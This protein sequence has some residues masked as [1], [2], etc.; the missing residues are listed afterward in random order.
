MLDST[1]AQPTFEDLIGTMTNERRLLDKLLFRHAEIAML[2]AAG[3][4]RFVSAA[5]DEAIEVEE[6]VGAVDLA[7]AITAGALGVGETVAE[8]AV[9]APDHVAERLL[10]LSQQMARTLEE[11]NMY[12]AQAAAWAGDRS[13]RLAKAIEAGRMGAGVGYSAD[14]SAA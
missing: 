9:A 4:H 13:A 1:I 2:I 12:R 8:I 3:E 7:R 11:V 10:L 14:G 5:I 6:E